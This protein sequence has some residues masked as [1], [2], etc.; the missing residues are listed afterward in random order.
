MPEYPKVQYSNLEIPFENI[1]F[2]MDFDS[3][4]RMYFSQLS[5]ISLR[6]FCFDGIPATIDETFLKYSLILSG[7][8]VF[9]RLDQ[10]ILSNL[11]SEEH[12]LKAGDLVALNGNNSNYQTIYY[13]H[14]N[15]LVTNPVMK[16]S[17][18]LTP[19]ED[20]EI[21]Y[22]TEPDRYKVFGHGGLFALIART[23][24]MLADNDISINCAQKN[25]RLHNVIAADDEPTAFSAEAAIQDM[26]N[27]KP[28]TVAQKSLVAELTG[29]PMTQN[30]NTNNLV[31]LIEMRQ[32][33]Y[34]HFYETIGLPAP[35]DNMKK[36]RLITDELGDSEDIS[37]LNLD[38]MH[39]SLQEGLK[40]VNAM[41]GTDITV[42]INP[43]VRRAQ[44][45]TE[46]EPEDQTE[47]EPEDQT[48]AEPEDQTEAEPEAQ[49]EAE[50]EDQ[51]ETEPEDQTEAEPED[52]TEA[53]PE[54]Q[55]ETE[56]EDQTE[57]EPED[58]T[59]AEPE[60]QTEA[61]PEPVAVEVSAEDQAQVQIIVQGGE[62]DVQQSNPLA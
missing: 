54:D 57:A 18:T 11:Q 15:V 3:L 43:I 42:T 20:C 29:I 62:S 41:F 1:S 33:I 2:E 37:A 53:E 44:D 46:A 21:V 25:T 49:T 58:Q 19:G 51:T 23:A 26:Y 5:Y 27:G 30:T 45:Q 48:E 24:T 38:D 17:Y 36:E 35:H 9:F 32:Y 60:D 16:K 31:Q 39:S 7:K 12:H 40:R 10:D 34:A 52:Q 56:P 8:I 22:L 14:R 6:L 55:T 4:Y 13:M 61:E 59:E 47:A 50:P 28:Y